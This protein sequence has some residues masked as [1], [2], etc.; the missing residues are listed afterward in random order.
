[1]D[2]VQLL[3]DLAKKLEA[4]D[5]VQLLQDLANKLEAVD[6]VVDTGSK[7]GSTIAFQQGFQQVLLKQRPKIQA[8]Y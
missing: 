7:S 2:K 5:K 4:A 3:K 1:M 8:K 6:M